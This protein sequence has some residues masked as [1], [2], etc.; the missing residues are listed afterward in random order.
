M[1]VQSFQKQSNSIHGE[2]F[3]EL[4][5]EIER[6]FTQSGASAKVVNEP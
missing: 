2:A 1:R 6:I 4:A 5:G 3:I